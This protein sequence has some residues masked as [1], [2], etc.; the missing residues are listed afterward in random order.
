MARRSGV[1]SARSSVSGSERDQV[2]SP[3]LTPDTKG[4]LKHRPLISTTRDGVAQLGAPEIAG[5][6]TGSLG[7]S[8]T[9]ANGEWKRRPLQLS[10]IDTPGEGIEEASPEGKGS[11]KQSNNAG[12]NSTIQPSPSMSLIQYAFVGRFSVLYLPCSY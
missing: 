11:S 5:E 6:R 4:L 9:P 3:T 2:A 7:N 10:P 8:R 1:A 12:S